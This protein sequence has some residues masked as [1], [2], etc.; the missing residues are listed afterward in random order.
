M[1]G[2]WRT[3]F[4][5]LKDLKNLET[6]SALA[7]ALGAVL[8]T[9]GDGLLGKQKTPLAAFQYAAT[10]GL[11]GV[12]A[13]STLEIRRNTVELGQGLIGPLWKFFAGRNEMANFEDQIGLV[14]KT[15]LIVGVQLNAIKH[16][17]KD[18]IAEK[19]SGGAKIRIAMLS[20]LDALGEPIAW[21]EEFG[22]VHAENDLESVL[23]TNLRALRK[24]HSDL[25]P[26]AAHNIEIRCYHE[27]P[28]AS[29]I[30]YDVAGK[31]GF[32]HVEP[33]LRRLEP[34]KRPV[35]WLRDKDDHTLYSAIVARYENLWNQATPIQK[36]AV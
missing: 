30:L 22:V 8:L 12:I 29:V 4:R 9:I 14:R 28:T 33:V 17:H 24:W 16:L 31:Q 5:D 1:Q 20:P 15:V 32:I 13:N 35:F 21:I 2:W 19:A 6:Y 34:S 26:K 23:R 27:I 18:A 36:I 10:L 3:I 25:P 11:L 7:V